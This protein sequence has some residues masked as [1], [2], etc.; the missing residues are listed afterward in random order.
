[1]GV[2]KIER[3]KNLVYKISAFC[4]VCFLVKRFSLAIGFI[5]RVMKVATQPNLEHEASWSIDGPL[6]LY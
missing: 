6:F 5:F 2:R 3:A 1:M 4:G